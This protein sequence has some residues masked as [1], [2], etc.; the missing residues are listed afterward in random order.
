M[1]R[2]DKFRQERAERNAPK[3]LIIDHDNLFVIIEVE[4]LK[5]LLE[6]SRVQ[7]ETMLTSPYVADHKTQVYKWSEVLGQAEEIVD[8]WVTCQKKWLYLLKIFDNVD[9]FMKMPEL[10]QRFEEVI[11]KHLNTRLDVARSLFPRLYFLSSTEIVELLAI[12]RN[13]RALQTCAKKCFHAYKLEVTE[14]HGILGEILPLYTHLEAY[15][16]ATK[17]LSTLEQHTKTTLQIVL[18]ACVQAQLDEGSK[19]PIQ[20]LEELAKYEQLSP[21]SEAEELKKDIKEQFSHWILR[22]PAQ[23]VLTTD[24]ILWERAVFKCLEKQDSEELKIIR[25]GFIQS[26]ASGTLVGQ[27][28]G[29]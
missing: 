9:F 20:L 12:S 17:W 4:E 7:V 14:I 21:R 29:S 24:A 15:S 5:Y 27:M 16:S 26:G 11:L 8:L 23:C 25:S 10:G 18:E 19:Q 13:P 1:R 6:D 28:Q 3:G 2:M 22:F